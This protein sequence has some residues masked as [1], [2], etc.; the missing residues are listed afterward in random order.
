MP[1]HASS[2]TQTHCEGCG[3]DCLWTYQFAPDGPWVCSR[4]CHYRFA[5]LSPGLQHIVRHNAAIVALMRQVTRA[6]VA[7]LERW[8]SLTPEEQAHARKLSGMPFPR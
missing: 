7:M 2:S 5:R 1:Y 8:D 6:H 3:R 4:E